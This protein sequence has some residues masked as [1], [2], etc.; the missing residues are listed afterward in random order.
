MIF[1]AILLKSITTLY[2]SAY[3]V[4]K[5]LEI[6][7]NFIKTVGI[8]V[9][10][11]IVT[12]AIMAIG[13]GFKQGAPDIYMI[14]H[15]KEGIWT[16]MATLFYLLHKR[17]KK[18]SNLDEENFEPFIKFVKRVVYAS[19]VLGITAVYFGIKLRGF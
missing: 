4:E 5:T 7:T 10:V 9:G 12:G 16:I 18:S 14:V 2:S 8:A 6:L 1:L 19:I 11:L 3:R 17:V 13:L 15:Y